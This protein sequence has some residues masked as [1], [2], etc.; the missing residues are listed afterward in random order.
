M[1]CI[2]VL[3]RLLVYILEGEDTL[4]GKA[5][6][7]RQ[8]SLLLFVYGW[9]ANTHQGPLDGRYGRPIL[10][11]TASKAIV[12]ETRQEYVAFTAARNNR[13]NTRRVV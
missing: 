8:L 12:T 5:L 10:M 7:V 13:R 1:H 2:V 11:L 9:H 3:F 6:L 4:A